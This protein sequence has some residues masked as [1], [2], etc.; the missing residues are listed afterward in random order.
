MQGESDTVH[1][2]SLHQQTGAIVFYWNAEPRASVLSAARKPQ[3]RKNRNVSARDETKPDC[4]AVLSQSA[5]PQ[6]SVQS[7]LL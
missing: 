1:A 3:Q 6:N 4:S 5:T 2:P 7:C